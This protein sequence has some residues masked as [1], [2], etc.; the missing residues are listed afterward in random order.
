MIQEKHIPLDRIKD[1]S[2]EDENSPEGVNLKGVDY[3]MNLTADDCSEKPVPAR[4][5]RTKTSKNQA[6]RVILSRFRLE[7]IIYR[8]SAVGLMISVFA[9]INIQGQSP[10]GTPYGLMAAGAM[11][12]IYL[13]SSLRLP[14]LNLVPLRH[15]RTDYH[16]FWSRELRFVL[17]ATFTVFFAGMDLPV[18]AFGLFLG[19]NLAVQIALFILW[20]WYNLRDSR[21]QNFRPAS[22]S[23]KN[24]I[25][26]GAGERGKRAADI[27]LKYPDLNIRVLGFVDFHKSG[28]WRYRD[29]PLMGRV[30]QLDRIINNNQVDA[31]IMAPEPEDYPASQDVFDLVENMGVNIYVP[32]FIYNRKISSCCAS[33]INGQSMLLYQPIKQGV[34]E[35]ILKNIMDKAGALAGLIISAPILL[36][37]IIAI[38]LDSRGPILFKQ[39]RSGLNG[40]VFEMLKLRTMVNDAER[41]KHELQHLN[42][43]TGPVFKIKDDP[44]VT[45]VGRILRKFSIDEFPQFINVLK[46]DMSLVG[47][48]PPLPA[49]VAQYEPWQRRR[50]SVKPGATCLWQINGRNHIDF[51]E[52]TRLDLQYIDQWSL[53]EDARILLKTL[54]AVLRGDGAS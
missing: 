38:K 41:Q 48:R 30:D 3:F 39:K 40:R 18:T 31:V 14:I 44:R 27:F 25:I 19:V 17:L 4:H 52:W 36:I 22:K 15:Q 35:K 16:R 28:L 12:A 7:L 23:E 6:E 46:G 13:L 9:L 42:E 53:K 21:M 5:P 34:P 29:V 24:V 1:M 20:R 51:E 43:M 50:L 26:F 37:S 8:L 2:A 11:A 47:P 45:R 49:E 32:P 10:L 54:P 33:S